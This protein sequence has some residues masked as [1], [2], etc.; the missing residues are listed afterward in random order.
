MFLWI[1][2]QKWLPTLYLS[3]IAL[4]VFGLLDFWLQGSN[5]LPATLLLV[6]SVA[7]SRPL[8][9]LSIF[10][11][12]A[13][14]LTPQFL[15][16][17]PQVAQLLATFSLLVLAAFG[18]KL[19]R[20]IGYALNTTAG[21]VSFVWLLLTLPVGGSFY[22]IELPTVE[23]K[24]AIFTAGFIAMIAVNA[25]AWFFGRLFITRVTH[26]GT[27]FDRAVLDR[28]IAN[29]QLA[30][31]EQD[32]RFEI[33]RDVNDLLLEQ[34]SATLSSAEAGIYS[35]KAD[36]T[37]APRLLQNIYQGLK[38]SHS[39]I[40]RLSD[41]L[42]FQDVKALAL[43]S[44]R[45][46]PKLFVSYREF[47]FGINYRSTGDALA[48]DD[49]AE[50]VI[51]RIVFESLENVRAHTPEGTEV[52]VD[53]MWHQEAL[54]V[55]VKDNGEETRNRLELS[56]TGYSPEEDHRALVERPTGANLT[57]LQE[58]AAL[59]GGSIDFSKVPGVGFTVSVAF[60]D[61]GKYRKGN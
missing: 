22:G 41:L 7:F 61:I 39:E 2:D 53:F 21:I 20:R 48:L 13:G 50:L 30:L 38:K 35:S 37:V 16:L 58:R 23:S 51:Y 40:R 57:A 31:A 47:G 12:T 27:N 45:D 44:L 10:L 42:K 5:T 34:V 28:E 55:V 11:F 14:I 17:D 6:G 4:V 52:D 26:V 46:L 25:N 1:R 19:Q 32:R 49:G 15:R 54:Q 24:Y 56:L 8:P 18:T 33:A 59:Y 3:L 29:T 60:P 9:W 36:P 43:P